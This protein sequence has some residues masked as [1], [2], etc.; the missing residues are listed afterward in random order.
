MSLGSLLLAME[1]T[2]TQESGHPCQHVTKALNRSQALLDL[3]KCQ[4]EE[5]VMTKALHSAGPDVYLWAMRQSLVSH[6]EGPAM[7]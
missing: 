1:N 4:T 3:M 6:R 7:C 2:F 5:Q